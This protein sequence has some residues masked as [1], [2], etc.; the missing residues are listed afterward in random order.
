VISVVI[1]VKNG[2]DDLVRCLDALARQRVADEVE[3]VVVDS[4]STDGSIEV[5]RERGARV[6]EIPPQEFNHGATRNL[7]AELA[8][9]DVLVFISQDAEPLGEEWLARL[10]APLSDD[11]RIAGAYGRQLAREDAVPPERY[12]LDFLYG[13]SPRTQQIADASQISMESTL[14]SNANSAM[15]RTLW[16]R[17]RFADDIIMSEDQD[18][19]RRV[20]LAGWRIA[21]EPEAVVRHS[22]PYTIGSAFRR[23]FDSGVSADRAYLAAERSNRALRSAA[24]RYLRGEL[25]WL[26]RSGQARWIPYA[27][28]YEL[29]K[30]AGLAL[31][32]RHRHLPLWLKL[33]CTMT[34]SYWTG[35]RQPGSG[36]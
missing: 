27:S 24:L 1:P 15:R 30:L 8:R 17:F 4:G 11:D 12:F 6:H 3:V 9:G 5:A 16:N 13:P 20:L 26:A 31:G 22:H 33:R 18:W 23:F 19:S 21:Y 7:G 29:A 25:G 14:F 2:G 10:V 32:A 36:A 35:D 34:P 28:V